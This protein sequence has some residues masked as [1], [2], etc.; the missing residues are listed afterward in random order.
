MYPYIYILGKPFSSY[1]LL[2]L[3]GAI[4]ALFYAFGICKS[5]KISFK[6]ITL[7][8]LYGIPFMFIGAIF[9][10]YITRINS[11]ASYMPYIFSDFKYFLTGCTPGLVFYGG[12]FGFLTGLMIYKVAYSED[13]RKMFSYTIPAIP[14][15]HAF[16]RVGCYL[17]G[18]CYGINGFPIQ[19]VEAAGNIVI[20]IILCII[21]RKTNRKYLTI[22]MYF[23]IYG[24]M[25]F[26]LEFFRGDEIRGSLLGL[27]TS[28]WISLFVVPFGIYC[29]IKDE[30]RNILNNWYK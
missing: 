25:R 1:S 27:S 17:S 30:E 22:G 14:L 3:L 28:Q 20:F 10:Y 13:V 2:G 23:A 4:A 12:L 16:G 26:I 18:C 6:K 7:F 15:F 8:M 29:L 9:L 11:I 19:L 5:Q 21:V 24:T